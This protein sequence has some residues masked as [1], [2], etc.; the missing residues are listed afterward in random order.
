VGREQEVAEIRA[1][2]AQ[3]PLVTLTGMGGIGKTR[4][5]LRVAEELA[6]ELPD[7]AWFVDLA[8]L[9]AASSELSGAE[10]SSLVSRTVARVLG[11]REQPNEPVS[12]ALA[13]ALRDRR[14]L[15]VLDNCEHLLDACA[16]LAQT[17]LEGCPHLQILTTSRQPLGLTG[18]VV[19]RVNPLSLPD[20]APWEVGKEPPSAAVRLFLERAVAASPGFRVTEGN[21]GLVAEVC[22]RLDG[23]PL[24]IELAA[25][26]LKALSV[27]ELAARLE[28]RFR[29]LTQG[30]RTAQPRQQTLQAALD[31]SHDLLSEPERTLLRRL[32]VFA[33][34]WTLAA[35]EAVC[36]CGASV[37]CEVLSVKGDNIG[38][39]SLTLNTQH[40]T[41]PLAEGDVLDLL[42]ALV[43]K[44]LVFYS[45]EERAGEGR[46]GL[47]ETVRQYAHERLLEAGEEPSVRGHHLSFFLRLVQEAEP[48][49]FGGEQGVWLDRLEGEH[50]NLHAAIDW[51]LEAEE[52]W[53][54]GLALT[55]ELFP[56]WDLRNRFAGALEYL[57]R[58]AARS[59]DLPLDERANVFHLAGLVSMKQANYP[60]ARQFFEESRSL[61]RQQGE[62]DEDPRQLQG[63]GALA[64]HEG[65]Y[66]HAAAL[67][68]ESI[69]LYREYEE[70]GS[71]FDRSSCAWTVD[72]LGLVAYS[73]GDFTSARSCYEQSL[74]R[75]RETDE[76]IGIASALLGLGRI[77]VMEG[78]YSRAHALLNDSLSLFRDVKEKHSAVWVLNSLAWIGWHEGENATARGHLV[79]ALVLCRETGRYRETIDTLISTGHLAQRQENPTRAARH[80]AAAEALRAAIGEAMPPVERAQYEGAIAAARAA[81]GE[82]AFAAAWAE[83]RAMT[84]EQAVRFALE[85]LDA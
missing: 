32:S 30:S 80:F 16:S 15:L 68:H 58:F 18:E 13:E 38:P 23:I 76:K 54:E 65:D 66:A 56:Y 31:W 44:S 55:R 73:V 17:L 27:E 20:D 33:G 29:L 8:P 35:A 60:A 37:E 46:Y 6:A 53:P 72:I 34:G 69:R 39:E 22:R 79:E 47:L 74:T 9:P 25:T 70:A 50:D 11:V 78:E 43:E 81:L 63:L 67:L 36:A 14:L 49:L 12:M 28:D 82:E 7:G 71:D 2:L 26:R 59:A 64:L 40:S 75:F 10:V 5:A 83:G 62:L 24:A 51:S 4:L 85:E 52:G 19:W 61:R 41:L 45:Y 1:R 21:A 84:R 42:T 77:A 48:K 3:G 57:K